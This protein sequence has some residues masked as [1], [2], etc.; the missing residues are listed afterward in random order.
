[1]FMID[2]LDLSL[3]QA[4]VVAQANQVASAPKS[5]RHA[6]GVCLPVQFIDPARP[7]ISDSGSA[8]GLVRAAQ[9]YFRLYNQGL[10]INLPSEDDAVLVGAPKFGKVVTWRDERGSSPTL[11][12][13]PNPG[14][15]GDDR[16]VFE[17]KTNQGPVRLIYL[18]KVSKLDIDRGGDQIL[19]KKTGFFWKLSLSGPEFET[20][21]LATRLRDAEGAG[22][23]G[24]M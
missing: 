20:A 6:M 10:E 2:L 17:I 18:L 9:D 11:A 16:L 8:L 24:R 13:E 1:M 12:Y 15:T 7:E 3:P 19:C 5:N 22:H 4:V 21:D 14:Y 23:A